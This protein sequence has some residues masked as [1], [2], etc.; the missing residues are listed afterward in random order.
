MC[1]VKSVMGSGPPGI[2]PP[3]SFHAEQWYPSNLPT[4]FPPWKEPGVDIETFRTLTP[5][6]TT[7]S[8]PEST[9]SLMTTPGVDPT[10]LDLTTDNLTSHDV[11]ETTPALGT[12]NIIE[13]SIA[14]NATEDIRSSNSSEILTEIE[15]ITE[16]SIANETSI[17]ITED[18]RKS[19][20]NEISN[21]KVRRSK[22][23]SSSSSNESTLDSRT[24]RSSGVSSESSETTR[25]PGSGR[26]L[27]DSAED[28]GT[29][30]SS[31]V[32]D[33]MEGN[34]IASNW[35]EIFSDNGRELLIDDIDK[36]LVLSA[37]S[38][39]APEVSS[40]LTLRDEEIEENS[41]AA[42]FS[43]LE[44]TFEEKSTATFNS[45][46]DILHDM[47]A[48]G[49]H[50]DSDG[51]TVCSDIFFVLDSS[52]NVLEQYEK[53]KVYIN[54]I[55][56]QLSDKERHYGLMTYAGRSRQRIN[57]PLGLPISKELFMRKLLRARFL[58]GITATGA[59]LR[60]A[61]GLQFAPRTDV[62]VITDGFSF[63]SVNAEA[64]R[65][66]EQPGVRVLV[67]GDYIPVV[68]EV[69]NNITGD[70]LNVLLGSRS[71]EQ[72]LD[73]LNC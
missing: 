38:S 30:N 60:T 67:A 71:I 69:L 23:S 36:L 61:A 3:L 26:G 63:D 40:N 47:P 18:S 17:E 48:E 14:S 5:P 44:D 15:Q 57:I 41:A 65:L 62:V 33:V 28:T 70:P 52:G 42:T 45:T 35:S 2:Q 20:S 59:A 22:E 66:R 6:S 24:S 12:G 55:L 13:L 27:L 7:T 68:R 9:S 73:L 10:L 32:L 8:S 39:L 54:N 46:S 43:T 21:E 4:V 11:N 56:M 49:V 64:Q 72:L 58:S 34:V 29:F 31:E 16:T 1:C 37:Q 19:S 25:T 50:N 53:Q 51:E